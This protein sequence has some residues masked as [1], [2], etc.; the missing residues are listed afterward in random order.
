[1]IHNRRELFLKIDRGLVSLPG[2]IF[3]GLAM[4]IGRI[5]QRTQQPCFRFGAGRGIIGSPLPNS[6]K[7]KAPFHGLAFLF[8]SVGIARMGL[9]CI[10]EQATAITSS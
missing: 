6:A 4:L 2:V 9:V 1:M 7:G 8:P 5:F 10:A 3:Q